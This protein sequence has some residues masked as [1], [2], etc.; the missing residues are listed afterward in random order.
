MATATVTMRK[1]TTE[2]METEAMTAETTAT[3]GKA[4]TG[5]TA[6]TEATMTE[7]KT[8]EQE[9]A[10]RITKRIVELSQKDPERWISLK[11][12]RAIAREEREKIEGEIN[13]AA[14]AEKE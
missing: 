12:L 3:M 6:A 2:A 14:I 10:E 13:A 9:L 4:T 1:A 5:T 7:A 8:K 11:E